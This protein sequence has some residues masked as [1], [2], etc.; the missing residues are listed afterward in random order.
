MNVEPG[1]HAV[2]DA[3]LIRLLLQNLLDN[4]GKFCGDKRPCIEVGRSDE[5]FFVRDHGIGFDPKHAHRLFKPF[6][7]LHREGAYPG[8]GIGLAN[9][10]R[11]AERHGGRV[12]AESAPGKGATFFFTLG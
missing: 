5:A 1:L 12:W 8:T 2:G 7:R 11:I 10:R 3:T 6:E 4:A 9:V